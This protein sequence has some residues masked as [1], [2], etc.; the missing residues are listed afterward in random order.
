MNSV[1]RKV[2]K[3]RQKQMEQNPLLFARI[4]EQFLALHQVRPAF[5]YCLKGVN[6]HPEYLPGQ[7]ILS[8]CLLQQ[9]REHDAL[10]LVTAILERSGSDRHGKELLAS[11]LESSGDASNAIPVWLDL[12]RIDPF[13]RTIERKLT[14]AVS[15]HIRRT[16]P[17]EAA[18][19]LPSLSDGYIL[20]A[21]A[22]ALSKNENVID[23]M[24]N[25]EAWQKAILAQAIDID[26]NPISAPAIV[27]PI[28]P[29]AVAPSPE[30]TIEV[31][32]AVIEPIESFDV[33]PEPVIEKH[34]EAPVTVAEFEEEVANES[35]IVPDVL[36]AIIEAPQ[37]APQA[38][39]EELLKELP[40][41][42]PEPL[43]ERPRHP[44]RKRARPMVTKTI[45]ELYAQ[46]GEYVRA[47]EVYR[48][49]ITLHAERADW[50]NRIIELEALANAQPERRR[51][52]ETD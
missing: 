44:Q 24:N 4:A 21:A 18:S 7:W 16:H 15:N 27:A 46:Q 42:E 34:E 9:K 10:R 50:Q 13:D 32:P 14:I 8:R 35:A 45:A 39:D 29:V 17:I 51:N 33:G 12:Y 48:E 1:D 41:V 30:I 22:E 26:R 31:E 19:S 23:V 6:A 36:S 2:L 20:C 47:I 52:D 28:E 5:Q 43:S 38:I 49:L 11:L 40:A 37:T 25:A 3:R